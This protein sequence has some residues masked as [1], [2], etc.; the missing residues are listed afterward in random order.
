MPQIKVKSADGKEVG[1]LDLDDK[2][3]G[4]EPS[5]ACVR[6]A[7]NHYMAAQ[8]T[9]T[10]S[11]KTRHFVRGGGAKPWK[12]KGTGR[13]RQG[14]IRA[15][16]W[17]GGAI[18]FGPHPRDYRQK[19]NRKAKASAIRSA[20]SELVKTERLIAVEDFGLSE[21]KTKR[22]GEILE[23]MGHKGSALLITENFDENLALSARNMPSVCC[24]GGSAPNIYELLTHD[25]VF[26]TKGALK[27]LEEGYA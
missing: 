5:L 21:P 15:V 26:A 20:L 14:S 24:V 9:G 2:V 10:H 23:A 16:Q 12:Q 27:K 7:L 13:A 18:A 11:T 6:A 17:R 3:F 4:V 1:T 22:L 25:Y 8:R 19:I